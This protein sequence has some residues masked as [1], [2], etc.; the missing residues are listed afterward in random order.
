M[1][2]NVMQ[3]DAMQGNIVECNAMLCNQRY[4]FQRSK[5]A[6]YK[7]IIISAQGTAS[8]NIWIGRSLWE[9]SLYVWH[10]GRLVR[11]LAL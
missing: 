8:T 6:A 7:E 4:V 5:A 3:C 2:C 1:Q 10:G 11:A 9:Q